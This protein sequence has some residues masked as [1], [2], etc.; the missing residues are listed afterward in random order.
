M[1]EESELGT[2][3]KRLA[4]FLSQGPLTAAI[5]SIEHEM[6]G[7]DA[8]GMV[9]ASASAGIDSSLLQAAVTVRNELGRLSD[10]IH[11]AA[12]ILALPHLLESGEVVANR[13]SLA[14]GNDPTRPFDLETNMRVAEFKLSQWGGGDA[15]RKR[16]VFKDLVHLAAD[17]SGRRPELFVVGDGPIRFLLSSRSTAAWALDRFPAAQALFGE[18]FGSLQMCVADF[19][20][21]PGARV[22]ITDLARIVPEF[23]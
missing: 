17:T 22:R 9:A 10:L 3:V 19:T 6:V 20:A 15:M 21:G 12:I 5:A 1:E 11:A 2:A 13:P 23:G 8:A 7:L 18:R 14:A 16:Q 4:A